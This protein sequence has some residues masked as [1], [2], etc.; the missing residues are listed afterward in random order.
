M[1]H[2]Y[3]CACAIAEPAYRYQN[4]QTMML[5]G[6]TWNHKSGLCELAKLPVARGGTFVKPFDI[7]AEFSFIG[8]NEHF[9]GL[10]VCMYV[11]L[12]VGGS[13]FFFFS[14]FKNRTKYTRTNRNAHNQKK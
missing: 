4:F 14:S 3:I 9:E 2:V 1:S 10:Y 7:L 13:F 12:Y 8:V 6:C 5:G 11:D